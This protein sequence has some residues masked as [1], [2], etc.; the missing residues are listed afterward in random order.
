MNPLPCENTP[1]TT[2]NERRLLLLSAAALDFYL[3]L[4]KATNHL[5][6][7]IISKIA[8]SF[9]GKEDEKLT[10]EEML[11][12]TELILKCNQ[13]SAILIF[14]FFFFFFGITENVLNYYSQGRN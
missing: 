8:F 14:F 3:C 9:N 6:S 7:I 12:N 10:R 5:N 11:R 4:T 1:I 2:M 13:K